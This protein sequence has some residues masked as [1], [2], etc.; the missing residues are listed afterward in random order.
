MRKQE[1]VVHFQ[2]VKLSEETTEKKWIDLVMDGE[3]IS[4]DG[5]PVVIKPSDI[6]MY[7]RNFEK[8]V[9][10]QEIPI[11]VDHPEQGGIAAGWLEKLRAVKRWVTT[12]DGKKV[13]KTVLQGLPSWTPYGRERVANREYRYISAELLPNALRAVSLVNFPAVKGMQPVE[14]GENKTD[15]MIHKYLIGGDLSMDETKPITE[16]DA[17]D[18]LAESIVDKVIAAFEE[19]QDQPEDE[20]DAKEFGEDLDDE[21]LEDLEDLDD[22]DLE[23]RKKLGESPEAL[24]G[25][26]ESIVEDKIKPLMQENKRLR[27]SLSE[28]ESLLG[29]LMEEKKR[30]ELREKVAQAASLGD[31]KVLSPA[32]RSLIEETIVS[33]PKC[34]EGNVLKLVKALTRQDAIVTLG[35]VGSNFNTGVPARGTPEFEKALDARAKELQATKGLSYLAAA[36]EA[37]KEFRS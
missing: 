31:G 27:K 21:D 37:M 11:T 34:I 9:R 8:N 35:E 30:A 6:E 29:K 10:G 23:E 24:L 2:P 12:I 19:D 5:S 25:L 28:T 22:E 4:M 36:K 33:D 16:E 7:I 3:Y 26:I 17:I 1:V 15:G 13:L 32:V 20:E 18:A 14:L